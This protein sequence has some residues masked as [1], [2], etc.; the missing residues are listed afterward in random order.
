MRFS[1]IIP[2]YNAAKYIRQCLDSVLSQ[3]YSDWECI[4]VDDGSTDFCPAI[5]DEYAAT[6]SRFIVLHQKNGGEGCARNTGLSVA[7]GDWI[8]WLDADDV[9]VSDRLEEANRLIEIE[10]PDMIRFRTIME[11]GEEFG[12]VSREFGSK[13]YFVYTG[14][15]AKEWGWNQLMPAGMVWTWVAR[16][17][18]IKEIPF[19]IGLRVKV[20][21]IYSG[22]LAGR[23]E[24]VVQ[25]E[26]RAYVYRELENSAIHSA[27]KSEDCIHFLA[28][29]DDLWSDDVACG[30]NGRLKEI[31]KRRLRMCCECDVIDWVRMREG[32]GKDHGQREIYAAYRRLKESGLFNCS[33]IQ[34]FRYRIPMWW[35]GMTGQ[36][37]PIQAISTIERIARR[38][39]G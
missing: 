24:K 6:D 30:E 7:R 25:S 15:S 39:K 28:A 5:L 19:R 31:A 21:C 36:I 29:V 37:W 8:T 17:E 1:I 27:R 20:D 34:Q 10:H 11:A 4:C 13:K 9:Y 16:R 22:W 32:D 3:T 12:Q 18:L 14:L 38:V 35:W 33:T 2:V 26:Y 23:L